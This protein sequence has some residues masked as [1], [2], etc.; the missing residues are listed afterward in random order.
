MDDVKLD[1]TLKIWQQIAKSERSPNEH[2][3]LEFYKKLHNIFQV[4]DFYHYIFNCAETRMEFV[5]PNIQ[6]V[7]GYAPNDFSIE[8][9]LAIIHPDDLHYFL[10]F[11]NTVTRF[12]NQL[13]PDK[14]LKYKVRY[15]YRIK[16]ADGNY[17]RILQQV[18]TIQSSEVGGVIRVMG[19]HTDITHLKKE[20]VSN[21]SFIGL[22]DE[23]SFID[24][25]TS[26]VFL[27]IQILTKREKQ[28]LK[29]MA[30]GKNSIIIAD[31]LSL[32]KNTIIT[33]RKNMLRKTD[34]HTT[35]DLVMKA[36]IEGWI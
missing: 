5:H 32:S 18:V 29:L 30:E 8:L 6:G 4:G 19:V 35:M 36:M 25:A 22:E 15:D 27:P 34:L 7:L 20:T 1:Q 12:F 13:S 17:V 14:I 9:L 2:F 26:D 31:E 10:N 23:P 11:E 24:V 3:E 28:I 16:K 21:L 33:H